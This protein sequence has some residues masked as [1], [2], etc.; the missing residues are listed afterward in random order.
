VRPPCAVC[1]V[2]W[3][4][5]L[6]ENVCSSICTCSLG[7]ARGKV[8]FLSVLSVCPPQN[9]TLMGLDSTLRGRKMQRLSSWPPC[10]HWWVGGGKLWT[11]VSGPFGH[12]VQRQCLTSPPILGLASATESILQPPCVSSFAPTEPPPWYMGFVLPLSINPAWTLPPN[13]GSVSTL[14][15]VLRVRLLSP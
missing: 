12:Q 11:P 8:T 15:L 2:G 14:L 1:A 10:S 4:C 5:S 13:K 6:Q 7:S 9:L 3:S